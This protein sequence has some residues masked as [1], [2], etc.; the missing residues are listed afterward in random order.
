MIGKKRHTLRN[1]SI[2]ILSL[3]ML[4]AGI[5]CVYADSLLNRINY[6]EGED[7]S[8][9]TGSLFENESG[10]EADNAKAG[11]LGGLY[12][13]DA[14]TNIL[15]LGVDNYQANDTGRSDSMM[16]VSV[17][18]RHK[19]IKL[20]SF[21]RDLYVAIPGIGNNRLNAAYS[22]AGGKIKGA[23]SVVRTLESNFGADIDRYV[24]IDNDAFNKIIDR[25]GGVKITL[26][27][28]EAKL[29]NQYSG[30]PRRN[31]TAGTFTLSG[32]QAH[33]YSR[34]RAIGD[35]FERTERQRKVFSSI[36]D[37][38]KGSSLPTIYSALA[39][40]MYLITTNM[41]KAE[42]LSMASN[43][44]TYLNYPISQD[45]IP[46]DNEYTSE[47]VMLGGTGADVL[48]PNLDKCKEDIAKFI[49]EDDIPSKTYQ[50]AG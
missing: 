44:L 46:G 5:G 14:I 17:D 10:G 43:S 40:T 34:I 22:L 28:A 25:L 20:T 27:A 32:A 12:H 30:D 33:Y 9:A 38:L 4:T 21:M 45:R 3:L 24:I 6:A 18:T 1:V 29:V 41:T 48:V 39:D 11:V 42:I 13:D 36:V 26:T 8:Q 35:D 50:N 19:K 7:S 37:S 23:Q 16:L 49:F 31:L 47:T 15:L 2:L